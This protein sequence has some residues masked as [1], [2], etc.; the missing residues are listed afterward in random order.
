M[1]GIGKRRKRLNEEQI[2]KIIG[3]ALDVGGGQKVSYLMSAVLVFSSS[4]LYWSFHRLLSSEEL[5]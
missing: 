3:G 2:R 4:D 5:L 1:L